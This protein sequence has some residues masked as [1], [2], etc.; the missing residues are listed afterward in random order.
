[1]CKYTNSEDVNGFLW[2]AQALQWLALLR[3][4]SALV[5]VCLFQKGKYV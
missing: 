4:V 3:L 1:M 2:G 5:V